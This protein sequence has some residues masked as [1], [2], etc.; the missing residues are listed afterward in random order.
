[1]NEFAVELRRRCRKCRS[2]LPAPVANEREA[3]CCR[4]CFK[5]FY[6]H[7]CF[8]CQQPM[9]RKTQNQKICGKRKCRNAL[10]GK[11]VFSR[12]STID[13]SRPVSGSNSPLISMSKSPLKPDLAAA[14]A[15]LPK[16]LSK[17]TH[18]KPGLE[19]EDDDWNLLNRDGRMVTR[20]RQEGDGY[21]V[22][23]PRMIPEPPVETFKAACRRA[24]TVAMVTLEPWPESERHPVHPGM[25]PSQ[26]QA[27]C[28]DLCRKH[29]DWSP[30]QVDQFIEQTLKPNAKVRTI[31][32]RDTPPISVTGGYKFPDAPVVDL[33]PT[34]CASVVAI[35]SPTESAD[36]A[37][38][39]GSTLRD[40]IPDDLSIPEFLRRRPLP[41]PERKKAA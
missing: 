15:W 29:S 13:T 41:Q 34:K 23:R 24:V 4:G 3:F 17:L 8:I 27:T 10:E 2:N 26:Y 5:A 31:I 7:R 11:T 16:R 32:K 1:M 12:F 30:A 25:T 22:A 36:H 37:D 28:R 38:C 19:R 20:V 40:Q 35:H 6:R 18:D 9:E 33:S 21:W 14:S 39:V